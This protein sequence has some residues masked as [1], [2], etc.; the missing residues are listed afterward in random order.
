MGSKPH[1]YVKRKQGQQH[2][3]DNCLL[4]KQYGESEG[5]EE[6]VGLK[7]LYVIWRAWCDTSWN[8]IQR[9]DLHKHKDLKQNKVQN[10]S[11]LASA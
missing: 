11:S 5:D 8:L 10:T 7:A 4:S 3:D 2:S 6:A 1:Q 9:A